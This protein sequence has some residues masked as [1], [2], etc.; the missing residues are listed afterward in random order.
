M[1]NI[2][3]ECLF[4]I[5]FLEKHGFNKNKYSL[6][7]PVVF[8]EQRLTCLFKTETTQNTESPLETFHFSTN[9]TARFTTIPNMAEEMAN[10][11]KNE[12]IQNVQISNEHLMHTNS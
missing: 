2:L 6:L 10:K 5:D 8:T 11:I 4:S 9:Q 7:C 12:Q 3:Q 1:K